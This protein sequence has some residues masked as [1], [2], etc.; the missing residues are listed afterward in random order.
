MRL[1]MFFAAVQI[2]TYLFLCRNIYL[3]QESI[4]SEDLNDK[5]IS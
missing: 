4:I 2:K 3:T 1:S 5:N